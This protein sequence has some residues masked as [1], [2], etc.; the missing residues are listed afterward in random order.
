MENSDDDTTLQHVQRY[1][2][3]QFQQHYQAAVFC[4]SA[5]AAISEC[6]NIRQMGQVE[7]D[8]LT[9]WYGLSTHDGGERPA[10]LGESHL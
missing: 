4:A 10:D 6:R 7:I 9:R 2:A 1:F 8:E 5:V 3:L